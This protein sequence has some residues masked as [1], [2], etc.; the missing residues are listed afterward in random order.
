MKYDET[1]DYELQE[2]GIEYV[3]S[4]KWKNE[5]RMIMDNTRK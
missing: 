5:V 1:K 4:T 3:R 2:D